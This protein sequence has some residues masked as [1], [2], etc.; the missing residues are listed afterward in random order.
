MR[1][2]GRIGKLTLVA[3]AA[4]WLGAA[5]ASAAPNTGRLSISGGVDFTTAYFF[6]GILQERDGFIIEPYAELG[7]NLHKDEGSFSSL[8]LIGG[9]WSSLHSEETNHQASS[10]SAYYEQD[11]YGG[12]QLGMFDNKIVSRAFYIAY[13]SPSDAFKT[14]QEVD[15]SAAFDDSEWL[16]A[17]ALKPTILFA[18]ETENTAMGTQPGQYLEIGVQPSFTV[19]Q[20][21]TYPVTLSLP[22]K[23]G[24]G[25]DDY[26]EISS[27]NEDTFGY[28]SSGVKLSIPLAFIPEDYGAWSAS[29]G[30]QVL[31]F[32]NNTR[33]LNHEDEV[34]AVGTWGISM[35]Y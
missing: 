6:R 7:I 26:Y 32:G 14:V 16:G 8:S 28:Y 9:T 29:G 27:S 35:S 13:T 22:N 17:F 34:W 4:A 30:V 1:K 15:L 5:S 20:S 3:I 2:A 31:A 11:W 19:I 18:T 12:L 10:L 21:D 25:L 24:L 33:T 23:V